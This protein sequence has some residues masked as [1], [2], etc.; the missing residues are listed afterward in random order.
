MDAAA[1]DAPRLPRALLVSSF[2]LPRRGGIEQFVDIAA[3]LL[4][5][6]GFR[7]RV[8]ACRPRAGDAEADATIPTRYLGTG[9]WPLP[10]RG[11]RTLWREV[12]DA[13][14]VVANGTRHL[15]PNLAAFAARLRGKRV[16]FVLHGSGASFSTSSFLYHRVF[17]SLFE[18]LLS[19][20]A[21]RVSEPVSLSRAGIAGCRRRYGVD[22]AYL[23]FPLR[24]L[25]P[26]TPTPLDPGEPLRIVWVGRLYGEK[27]P[28]GAVEVV[29]QVL[30]H[31]PASLELYGSGPLLRELDELAEDRPWLAVRG[32]RSWEEIQEVQGVA[33]VCLSTSRRDATQIAIL[34]PLAR[35]VPVVSTRVGDAL[36]YYARGLWS[37][38]VEPGDPKA[39]AEAILALAASYDRYRE[40]F[41]VNAHEL[42]RRHGDAARRLA[43]LLAHQPSTTRNG[44]P[45]GPSRAEL[46]VT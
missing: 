25:P 36:G 13:D 44:V 31:R 22:A 2:V 38:C 21:L 37:F 46:P 14:V 18:R 41:A 42:T 28:L 33:H 9:G 3:R 34:E 43:E 1:V 10:V 35:G 16:I 27:N 40:R 29:E 11:L 19:R 26:P 30:K 39:A 45:A 12:G 17:G 8:L 7:V 23:P 15:L 5:G 4:R 24:E 20:P 6:Q 32:T